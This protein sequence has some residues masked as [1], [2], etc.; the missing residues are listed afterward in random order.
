MK[1]LKYLIVGDSHGDADFIN[2]AV[3]QAVTEDC[4]KIIQVGDFGYFPHLN[5]GREFLEKIRNPAIP[6]WWLDGNHENHEKLNHRATKPVEVAPGIHYLPRGYRWQ[7]G[8]W[9][10]AALGGT[11]S[12][13]RHQR[14]L[15][16]DYWEQETIS[17]ADIERTIAPGDIDI[18]F[19]HECPTGVEDIAIK[20]AKQA[21]GKADRTAIQTVVEVCKPQK[22]FHGH[23]HY[24]HRSTI[25]LADEQKV[26][27]FGLDCNLRPTLTWGI[28]ELNT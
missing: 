20:G 2:L 28:L 21:N 16:V 6:I 23:H 14:T 17:Y 12:I 3:E 5:E 1:T 26:E 15:G 8:K 7:A 13:D 27:V 24:H 22:V 11:Q 4:E 9:T 18:L 25:T 19:C 10:L